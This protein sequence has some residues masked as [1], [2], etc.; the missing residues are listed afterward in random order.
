MKYIVIIY[1]SK[2]GRTRTFAEE[3][4][5]YLKTKET[6]VIKTDLEDFKDVMLENAGYIFFGCWTHGLFLI[7][8]HPDKEWKEFAEKMHGKLEVKTALFTTYKFLTGS[9]F[10][11]M[12]KY[13]N[14]K[15]DKP[16]L[17]LKSK[18]TNLSE[19]DKLKID[20]FLK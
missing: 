9:M 11:N 8:Q 6:E 15:F 16:T 10:K 17:Y 18:N 20:E 3:L 14:N 7:M 1:H 13:L 4:E 19:K 2:T 12:I 5:R